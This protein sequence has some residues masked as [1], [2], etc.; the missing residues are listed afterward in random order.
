MMSRIRDVLTG[1]YGNSRAGAIPLLYGGSCNAENV[2]DFI[3][4]NDINGALVG[5]ASLSARSFADIV[6][7]TSAVLSRIN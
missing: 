3:Q 1:K 2:S 6:L 5:G 4:Q 7:N